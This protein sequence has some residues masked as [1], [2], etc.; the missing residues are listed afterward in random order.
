MVLRVKEGSG[1][2]E[3]R[4]GE[5]DQFRFRL[6]FAGGESME[7]GDATRCPLPAG[8]KRA[9]TEW[10][11]DDAGRGAAG[12]GDAGRAPEEP[13][14]KAHRARHLALLTEKSAADRGL[15]ELVFGDTEEGEGLLRRLQGRPSAQVFGELGG[16]PGN[17]VLPHTF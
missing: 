5:D 11:R 14:E 4:N 10:R 1:S 15:E 2:R 9:R 13:M 8:R 17:R 3:G 7:A 12:E 6:G 16:P